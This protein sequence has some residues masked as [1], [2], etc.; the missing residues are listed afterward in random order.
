MHTHESDK[1]K[2]KH[3]PLIP[4]NQRK[5]CLHLMSHLLTMHTPTLVLGT[6]IQTR[7]API[8]PAMSHT[9]NILLLPRRMYSARL[10]SSCR[11]RLPLC[12]ASRRVPHVRGFSGLPLPP[13]QARRTS[14]TFALASLGLISKL[15]ILWGM[16]KGFRKSIHVCMC[17]WSLGICWTMTLSISVADSLLLQTAK[18][19]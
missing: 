13:S 18:S 1:I 5:H 14:Q 3:L 2:I 4:H 15:I 10:A 7:L 11:Y 16:S 8:Q 17:S 9:Q 12:M 19:G 6:V